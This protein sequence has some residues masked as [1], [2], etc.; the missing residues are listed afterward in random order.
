MK[1]IL[2]IL[3]LFFCLGV[4]AQES[5]LSKREKR[6]LQKQQAREAQ[7]KQDSI[8][9]I[10]VEWML[11]NKHFVLEA[12]MIS[13][14]GKQRVNVSS[15]INFVYVDSTFGAV[16]IGSAHLIGLNGV[17]GVTVEGRITKYDLKINKGRGGK[18]YFL[19]L[20]VSSN[21]GFFDI[22]LNISAIG[23]AD[24]TLSGNWG[25]KL[26]YHGKIVALSQSRVYK[27]TPVY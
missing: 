26:S 21:S 20:Y 3:G 4:S 8:N 24:A 12:E 14:P 7:A 11:K 10:V 2:F 5:E 22:S 9:A 25:G 23:V 27:G 18:S 1:T 17:G 13:A 6:R 16:Q 15:N 19:M